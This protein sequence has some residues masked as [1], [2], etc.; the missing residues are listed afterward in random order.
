MGE[1]FLSFLAFLKKLSDAQQDFGRR[2]QMSVYF[3]K[4]LKGMLSHSPLHTH[5]TI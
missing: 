1:I 3:Q 4:L 5:A 2:A